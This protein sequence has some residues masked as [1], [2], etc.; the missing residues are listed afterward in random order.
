MRTAH[1]FR[2]QTWAGPGSLLLKWRH[3][4]PR[5]VVAY[6]GRTRLNKCGPEGAS[7]ASV[8]AAIARFLELLQH[9]IKGEAAGLLARRIFDV[10]LQV[11]PHKCLRRH[12]QEC[13]I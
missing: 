2:A 9:L 6:S 7:K 13:V 3:S 4:L 12:G 8:L 11:L 10:A 1:A 5:P